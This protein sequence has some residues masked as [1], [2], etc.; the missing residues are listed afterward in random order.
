RGVRRRPA[1]RGRA[2][3]A[4]P[5]A[6]A[7]AGGA[8]AHEAA[9]ARA[10]LAVLE[11]ERDDLRTGRALYRFIEERA[12]A[13]DYRRHLGLVALVRQDSETLARLLEPDPDAE[14]PPVERIVLYVDDLDRCSAHRVV[15]VLEA[16][17]L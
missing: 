7:A 10:Q 12:G 13:D 14:L 5:R 4:R 15:K 8:A 16:V 11:Q 2:V 17:H 3:D 6:L 9:E 1:A